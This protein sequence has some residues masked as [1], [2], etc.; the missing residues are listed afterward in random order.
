MKYEDAEALATKIRN[1]R[2][3]ALVTIE[4]DVEPG[5]YLIDVVLSFRFIVRNGDQWQRRKEEIKS[6]QAQRDTPNP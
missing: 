6:L 1:E 5:H 4:M 3:D 2:P